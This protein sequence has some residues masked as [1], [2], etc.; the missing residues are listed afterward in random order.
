MSNCD[1][2]PDRRDKFMS[3]KSIVLISFYESNNKGCNESS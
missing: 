1:I 2:K 3:G